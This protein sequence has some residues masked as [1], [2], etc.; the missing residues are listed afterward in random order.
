MASFDTPRSSVFWSNAPMASTYFAVPDE[1]I[2]QQ[3]GSA[4]APDG[5]TPVSPS[6]SQPLSWK[7]LMGS[8]A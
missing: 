7:N 1:D 3:D 6:Q 2:E 8:V 5:R 4:E